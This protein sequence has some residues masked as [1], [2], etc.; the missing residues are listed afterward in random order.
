[1]T[2]I[3]PK[4]NCQN[5]NM[6]SLVFGFI[7]KSLSHY[8]IQSPL[9]LRRQPYGTVRPRSRSNSIDAQELALFF[10]KKA[11]THDIDS[12]LLSKRTPEPGSLFTTTFEIQS[13]V[14]NCGLLPAK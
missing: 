8:R 2:I 6:I 10:K 1:M 3:V 5:P 13:K 9:T 14:N 11:K 12:R 7:E 4:T